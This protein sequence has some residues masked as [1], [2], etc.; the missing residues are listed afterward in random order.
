MFC[1]RNVTLVLLQ[2][3]YIAK[4]NSLVIHGPNTDKLSFEAWVRTFPFLL[5]LGTV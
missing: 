2:I 3:E 5:I 1:I 4:N